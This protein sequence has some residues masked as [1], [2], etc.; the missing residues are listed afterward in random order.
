[1][2]TTN[3]LILVL[4]LVL[5]IG[6]YSLKNINIDLSVSEHKNNTISVSG[7]AEKNVVPD[8]ARISFSVNEYH[9]KQNEAADI[10]NKK[11]KK[12]IKALKEIGLDEKDIKTER[13]SIYPE[14]DWFDGKRKFRDYRASQSVELKIKDLE[15]VQKVLATLVE[16]KADNVNGPNMFVDNREKISESLRAE[17]IKN[18]KNKA[19]Q[20][21]SEL[22]VSLDKIVA[23]SENN[24]NRNYIQPMYKMVDM[25]T[26]SSADASVEE[27]EINPGEEKIVKNVTIT[28]EI[29]N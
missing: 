7:K 10:V 6:F 9:K 14:Y 27:P 5:G 24:F 3:I 15:L 12:I 20:L 22:G 16:Y 25:E 4:I 19:K 29:K 2:K 23:F 8:T 13:Y 26:V 21:A 18:A 11:V 17:A 1:M 28:F